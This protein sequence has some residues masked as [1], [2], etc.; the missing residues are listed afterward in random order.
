[1]IRSRRNFLRMIAAGTA[2]VAARP[3]R[4]LASAT[5]PAKKPAAKPAQHASSSS[6][7]AK[8]AAPPAALRKGIEQQQ[9][10]LDKAL[11]TLRDYPLLA[12]SNPAFGFEVQR[13]ERP[14][15]SS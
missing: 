15:R 12:G 1:M 11:K 2:A 9:R 4:S 3:A 6:A 10:D 5:A 14:R 13:V 8:P 7:A